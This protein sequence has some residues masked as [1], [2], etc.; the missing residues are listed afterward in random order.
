[1]SNSENSRYGSD[2]GQVTCHFDLECPTSNLKTWK[3]EPE[4]EISSSSQV[5]FNHY[6]FQVFKF[7]TW[8]TRKFQVKFEKL[9]TWTRFI[10]IRTSKVRKE[11]HYDQNFQKMWNKKLFS[12]IHFRNLKLSKGII[13]IIKTKLWTKL[14]DDT[15]SS[16]V[17]LK[18]FYKNEAL[19]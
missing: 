18:A 15:L 17:F 6:Q 14:D 12:Y 3:L 5:K 19:N 4:L 11:L 8:R 16:L 1:M 7:K 2:V 9:Q 10:K 13:K